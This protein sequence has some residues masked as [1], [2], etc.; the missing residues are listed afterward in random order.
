MGSDILHC[1]RVL[2]GG[3]GVEESSDQCSGQGCN[4]IFWPGMTDL[5]GG[6][7][8]HAPYIVYFL[9]AAWAT[10]FHRVEE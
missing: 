2:A 3:G 10:E 8:S 1:T 4:S 6:S 5:N 7:L 9:L